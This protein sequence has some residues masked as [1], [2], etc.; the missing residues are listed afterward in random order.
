MSVSI[1]VLRKV[2]EIQ[3]DSMRVSP[4]RVEER[5]KYEDTAIAIIELNFGNL[6]KRQIRKFMQYLDMDFSRGEPT[7]GRFGLLLR[8]DTRNRILRNDLEKLNELFL[9]IYWNENLE[10]ANRLVSELDGISDGFVSCLLYLKNRDKYN[11][12]IPA[13]A[14]GIKIAFP[15]TSFVGSF[16]KRFSEFNKLANALKQKCNL[17]SQQMDIILTVLGEEGI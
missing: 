1:D 4:L 6:T 12:F 9:E 5:E 17:E 3:A 11:V 16:K 8:G 13:T 7:A 2:K 10:E 14:E 15:N